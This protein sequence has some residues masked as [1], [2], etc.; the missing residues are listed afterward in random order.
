[1]NK[2]SIML[3]SFA[4]VTLGDSA[5]PL[6]GFLLYEDQKEQICQSMKCWNALTFKKKIYEKEK[7]MEDFTLCFRI[8]LLSYRGKGLW[9]SILRAKTNKY[10]TNDDMNL[11][12]T[13]GFFYDLSPIDGPGNGVVGIQT[14]NDQLQEVILKNGAYTIWPIYETEVNAHQWNSFCIGSN[15]KERNIFLARNGKTLHNFSQPELWATLN[16]GLDTT[17]L[18]PLNVKYLFSKLHS[19]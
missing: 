8:N 17:A 13:T 14:F 9:H 15:L 7:S 3:L 10:K 4:A 19:S 11:D 1:M 12:W 18:E 5:K 16:V 6:K 2:F